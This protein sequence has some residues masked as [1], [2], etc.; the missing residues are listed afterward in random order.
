[1][2]ETAPVRWDAKNDLLSSSARLSST[3]ALSA[4]SIFSG[5]FF[6]AATAC[7]IARKAKTSFG[8]DA[9]MWSRRIFCS[10]GENFWVVSDTEESSTGF[11]SLAN[12][13][14]ARVGTINLSSCF[15]V[16]TLTN[17]RSHMRPE[18]FP[19]PSR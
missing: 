10:V 6:W 16:T 1:M 18:S 12:S 8:T 13:Q 7:R 2:R 5:D 11:F 14:A 3:Y 19:P 15:V 17:F 4:L 9:M